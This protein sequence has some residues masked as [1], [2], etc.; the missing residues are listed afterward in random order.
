MENDKWKIWKM[1]NGEY[2]IENGNLRLLLLL[3]IGW[4]LVVVRIHSI[5]WVAEWLCLELK[6]Q[7]FNGGAA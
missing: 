6:S 4:V 5:I 2:K 7:E 1:T 3:L